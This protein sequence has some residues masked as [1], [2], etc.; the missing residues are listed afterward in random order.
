MYASRCSSRSCPHYF[1]LV[2]ILEK[3]PSSAGLPAI[4]PLIAMPNKLSRV[5]QKYSPSVELENKG[6][7]ARDHLA[8]ERTFLAWLRTALAFASI[9]VAVAQLFRLQS[10]SNLQN[11]ILATVG[12][13]NEE[14]AR[15]QVAAPKFYEYL[16]MI[17]AQDRKFSKFSTILGA[18]FIATGVM[19]M[20]LGLSRYF[21]SQHH[22][23]N[24]TFPVSRVSISMTFIVTLAV[25]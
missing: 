8:N 4:E 11:L 21:I 3:K 16:E 9:G 22:L 7:V 19:V 18:W 25:S 24:G 5:L 14:T 10:S 20:I 2:E 6:A 13:N 15:I 1:V 23:Q 12:D 17:S